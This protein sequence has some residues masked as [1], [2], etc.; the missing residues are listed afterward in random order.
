MK[1][2]IF[3]VTGLVCCF[4]CAS[5]GEYG[6]VHPVS[7]VTAEGENETVIRLRNNTPGRYTVTL[8]FRKLVNAETDKPVP[9]TVELRGGSIEKCLTVRRIDRDKPWESFFMYDFQPGAMNAKHDDSI[10]YSLPYREGEE[11]TVMQ[12]YGG[13]THKGGFYYSIDWYMPAGSEV[14]AAREG[15]VTEAVD[16]FDGHGLKPFYYRRDNRVIIEHE[17]GTVAYYAHFMK[18]GARVKPGDKVQR[19]ELIGLSGNVGYSSAAH[20]HFSVHRAVDGRRS[21][22]V[23]VKFRLSEGE[24]GAPAWRETLRAWERR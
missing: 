1:L 13:R 7:V 6:T 12:G 3:A 20:L 21:E 2:N 8:Y 14:L 17:D 4:I 23:P 9:Y 15:T 11:Y 10:T 24:A 22:S 5:A 18:G 16:H 19:G